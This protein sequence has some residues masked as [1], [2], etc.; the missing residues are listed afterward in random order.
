MSS[1][2]SPQVPQQPRQFF[3]AGQPLGSPFGVVD[4]QRA[5]YGR[6]RSEILQPFQ[7]AVI[8]L[9]AAVVAFSRPQ[10]VQSAPRQLVAEQFEAVQE[11]TAGFALG[12]P[13]PRSMDQTAAYW[14]SFPALIRIP[15]A[16][17][18]G[19]S[20]NVPA[21]Q[22]QHP[23]ATQRPMLIEIEEAL[24]YQTSGFALTAPPPRA[25]DQLAAYWRQAAQPVQIS[26][27]IAL[28]AAAP[29][30]PYVSLPLPVA[31]RQDIA[32][33]QGRS[34]RPTGFALSVPPTR[35][36]DQSA[37]YFRWKETVTQPPR[38]LY[39]MPP[40]PPIV[41]GPPP[42]RARRIVPARA[43]RPTVSH[44]RIR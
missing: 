43:N 5:A 26:V 15:V 3:T 16:M 7:Y 30:V 22:L 13:A 40:P 12:V 38:L 37:A 41:A 39:F 25:N 4:S 35:P 20:V 28:G 10:V 44:R 33:L 9:V 32:T 34:R 11:F 24:P 27:R 29:K 17:T 23:F 19:T 8:P 42:S 6:P 2:R 36:V 18:A 1:F 31:N 14:R 21:R